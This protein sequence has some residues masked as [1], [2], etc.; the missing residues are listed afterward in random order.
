MVDEIDLTWVACRK[1][2]EGG[3][4]DMGIKEEQD[5]ERTNY[6]SIP[7]MGPRGCG[8]PQTSDILFLVSK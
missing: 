5:G 2:L 3:L 6:L 1:I 7:R 8:S 4:R